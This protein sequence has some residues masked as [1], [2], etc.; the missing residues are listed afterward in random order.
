MSASL[1][2]VPTAVDAE[3]PSW[4]TAL[5]YCV[6]VYVGI[7]VALFALGLLVT[8][9]LPQNERV[10]VPGWDAPPVQGGWQNIGTAW[11]RSDA[12]W[13]LSIAQDGY[14]GDDSSGAF[15][16]LYPSLIKLVSLLFGGG[17]ELLSAYVVTSVALLAGLVVLY[18][19]TALEMSEPAARKA[20]LYLCLFP[21]GFFLFAPYTEALFLALS[22]GTLYAARRREWALAAGLGVLAALTRSPGVLLALPLA[23]EALLQERAAPGPLS[24]RALRLAGKLTAAGAA[25]LGLLAY[26]SYWELSGKGDFLRPLNLQRSGFA[27]EGSTPWET[28]VDG[29]RIAFQFP[30]QSPGGYFAIDWIVLVVLAATGVWVALRL[31][32]TWSVYLWVSLLFPLLLQFPGRPLLSLPRI[33]LVVFPMVWGLVRLAERGRAHDAV[34]ATLAAGM[35]LCAA[36]FVSSYPLF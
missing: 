16:P 36:L 21:T 19:L 9:L 10:G 7:R 13:Y 26:L 27:K 3:L 35:G 11:E 32:A 31:R 22:V 17:H 15:F 4:R 33:Y 24:R 23:V 20:V 28:I 2:A 25:G 30:G 6:K 12:L 18:R 34:L 5:T 8:G 1:P 14:R 29:T